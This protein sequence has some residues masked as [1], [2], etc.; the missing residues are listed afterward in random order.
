MP[1]FFSLSGCIL[2]GTGIVYL[3]QKYIAP[4][5]DDSY[6]S[7][8]CLGCINAVG[9]LLS[10]GGVGNL[11][12]PGRLHEDDHPRH[13]LKKQATAKEAP[14]Q[15]HPEYNKQADKQDETK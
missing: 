9:L 13:L 6:A 7:L 12:F 2:L 11:A 1:G 8:V 14:V 5:F 10:V 3:N 4:A 15:T